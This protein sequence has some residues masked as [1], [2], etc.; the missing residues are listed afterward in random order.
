MLRPLF[1][2]LK[3]IPTLKSSWDVHL[4]SNPSKSY[5]TSLTINLKQHN[6]IDWAKGRKKKHAK[7]SKHGGK[8]MVQ[9]IHSQTSCFWIF[10]PISIA[11]PTFLFFSFLWGYM[12]TVVYAV[13]FMKD[14]V[15]SLGPSG[16]KILWWLLKVWILLEG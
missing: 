6:P 8:V 11:Y 2:I 13:S 9:G 3:K 15:W 1:F 4:I 7:T 12:R 14:H 16:P 10:S 5:T